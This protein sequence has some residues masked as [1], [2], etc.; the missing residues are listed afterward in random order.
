MPQFSIRTLLTAVAVVAIGAALWVAEPSWQVGAF[1]ALLLAW[2]PASAVVL[3]IYCDRKAKPFWIGVTAQCLLLALS[4]S[5]FLLPPED[6]I[7]VTGPG[8]LGHPSFLE[9]PFGLFTHL[10]SKFRVALVAW[11]FA[12]V[13][14][15]LCVVTHRLFIRP[16][17]PK[18]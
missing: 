5:S 17:E 7:W 18:A 4:Y 9:T 2:V 8:V 10:S 11:A 3:S 1:E 12:P 15:V 14:G 6:S 16:P 13:V